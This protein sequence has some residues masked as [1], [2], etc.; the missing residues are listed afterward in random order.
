MAYER[1]PS[2]K[3]KKTI[4]AIG[5]MTRK[6]PTCKGVGHVAIAEP[7]EV[8]VGDGSALV[9]T[10]QI[11]RTAHPDLVSDNVSRETCSVVAL[12]SEDVPVKIKK[13]P[14][15]KPKVKSNFDIVLNVS[16]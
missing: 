1:C 2:C 4:L 9:S 10:E 14:G 6:C 3:G 7:L 8:I 5:N 12:E 15:R 11:G 13:K 16:Q